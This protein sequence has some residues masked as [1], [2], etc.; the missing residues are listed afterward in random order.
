MLHFGPINI[1]TDIFVFILF[2][3]FLLLQILL[4]SKVKSK[5]LRLIP[6]L[7]F[8]G[9]SV[10]FA[11]TAFFFDGWDTVGFLFL[12]ICSAVLLIACG[13]GWLIYCFVK[14]QK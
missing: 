8:S 13:I 1:R 5:L 3:A 2:F 4:C 9:A 7:L 11:I 12:A 14:K 6:V 10:I